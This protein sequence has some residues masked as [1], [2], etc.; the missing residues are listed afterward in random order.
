MKSK[1]AGT[2]LVSLFV[3]WGFLLL[4]AACATLSHAAD[5]PLDTLEAACASGL[6]EH[7]AVVAQAEALGIAD[8]ATVAEYLCKIPDV[9]SVFAKRDGT[10]AADAAVKVAE[11]RGAL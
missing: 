6:V 8:A 5:D 4:V 7:P 2:L 3:G 11:E 9:V 10:D 1:T